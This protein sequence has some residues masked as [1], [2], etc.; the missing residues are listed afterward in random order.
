LHRKEQIVFKTF[1]PVALIL[2][3][4]G[5]I[6]VPAVRADER[7]KKTIINFSQPVEVAGHVLPAGTYTFQL[8]DSASDRHI[9]QIFGADGRIVATV[10]TIP[11]YRL[12]VT[13]ETVIKFR[14]VPAGSPQAIRAWFYPGNSAGQ[15]FVYPKARALEL[16]K[17]SN[18]VV[19][20]VATDV[21][22]ADLT[23]LK[24]V[25]I[26]AITPD[27]MELPVSAA[28][29]TTPPADAGTS[30]RHA[31]RMPKTASQ[32]PLIAL[33]GLGSMLIAGAA[34]WLGRRAPAPVM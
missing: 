4:F 33:F 14:E 20:A 6:A 12:T 21:A 2:S 25:P 31:G 10:L 7:N 34:M 19:P 17:A 15:E 18:A 27:A 16:A 8:A 28:I 29:R 5:L 26:V 3:V 30:V 1:L 32:L 24:T 13:D 11:D 22:V 23:T 9:V